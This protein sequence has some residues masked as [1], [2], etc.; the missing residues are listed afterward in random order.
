MGGEAGQA[1]QV[2]TSGH[3][4]ECLLSSYRK[5]TSIWPPPLPEG[6]ARK[7]QREPLERAGSHCKELLGK[8]AMSS[9]CEGPAGGAEPRKRL[10]LGRGRT[11]AGPHSPLG[12][13]SSPRCSGPPRREKSLLYL[14]TK[15]FCSL[16]RPLFIFSVRPCRSRHASGT[17]AGKLATCQGWEFPPQD[18]RLLCS[19]GGPQGY[20][21][22]DPVLVGSCSFSDRTHQ[23]SDLE[24]VISPL[25]LSDCSYIK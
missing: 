14:C 18:K 3:S 10:A 7:D 23:P 19:Q 24:Q 11:L 6:L 8:H 16:A 2:L 13:L 5:R 4:H 17:K 1:S 15:H 9:G 25:W 21:G 12:R 22:E 20:P